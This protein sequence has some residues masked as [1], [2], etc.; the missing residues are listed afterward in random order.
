MAYVQI[1][2]S[3]SIFK[4]GD[5][6]ETVDLDGIKLHRGVY[7]IIAVYTSEQLALEPHTVVVDVRDPLF[8]TIYNYI[9]ARRFK[10]V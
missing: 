7:E 5:V 3:N 2:P 6:V 9:F 1:V 10:A 8:G 4:V